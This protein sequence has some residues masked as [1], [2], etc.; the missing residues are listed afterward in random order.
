MN[1]DLKESRLKKNILINGH[2]AV[3]HKVAKV[4]S[5]DSVQPP[6]IFLIKK[7]TEDRLAKVL[8]SSAEIKIILNGVFD[9]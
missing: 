4:L 6:T 7:V 1:L 5:K 8:D 2:W 3:P 9:E